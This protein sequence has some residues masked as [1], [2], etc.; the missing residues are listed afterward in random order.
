MSYLWSCNES[1]KTNSDIDKTQHYTQ[2]DTLNLNGHKFSKKEFNAIVDNFPRLYQDE[3][4]HPDSLYKLE[5]SNPN[6]AISY[7]QNGSF[8]SDAGQD[9][10]FTLYAYFLAIKNKDSRF[11]Y[12][13][14][15]LNKSYATINTI[16]ERLSRGSTHYIHQS[17]C[18]PA[19]V[20]YDIYFINNSL[21]LPEFTKKTRAE[22]FE[23]IEELN[24]KIANESQMAD[25]S[26]ESEN[27]K[28]ADLIEKL[29]E[30]IVNDYVLFKSKEFIKP[31]L[32][33]IKEIQKENGNL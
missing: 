9:R 27:E 19:Y 20:E 4:L 1:K 18:I 12:L 15:H 29:N 2:E 24:A 5:F 33:K 11:E 32:K 26:Y 23:F 6:F 31:Y 28:M 10:F 16:F 7:E 21:R 17:S 3:V 8:D 13:R 30:E 22:R 25:I 14:N